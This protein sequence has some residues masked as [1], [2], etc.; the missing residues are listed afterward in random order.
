MPPTRVSL[1][2]TCLVDLLYPQVGQ[3]TVAV[4]EDLGVAVDFP[5]AQTCCGQPAWNA[6]YADDARRVAA[7]LLDA[8]EAAEAVVSPSGSCAGMVRSFY[9]HMF[10]G[11]VDARR[12]EALADRTYELSEFL[13]DVLGVPAGHGRWEGKV[14]V[15]DSCHGLREVGLSGQGRALMAASRAW[16][17]WRCPGPTCAA[18]SVGRSRSSSPRWPRPWP[19]T[20]S[21][22]RRRRAPRP[23]CP[24][25]RGA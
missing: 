10:E 5:A 16:R 11:T 19:T 20:S 1:F 14:T 7:N 18:G 4:L 9:P 25:T 12:A 22:S 8:M 17:W 21:P 15:H 3:A 2:V 13:V 6:G 23:S 24:A